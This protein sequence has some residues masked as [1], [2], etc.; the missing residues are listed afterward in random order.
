MKTSSYVLLILFVLVGFLIGPVIT[1]WALNT[2]FGLSIPT[3]FDTW[4]GTGW[5]CLIVAAKSRN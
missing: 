4:L 1:I 2:V 3:T 5:L